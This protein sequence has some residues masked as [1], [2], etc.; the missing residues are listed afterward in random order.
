M[1]KGIPRKALLPIKAILPVLAEIEDFPIQ[2]SLDVESLVLTRI[3]FEI[4]KA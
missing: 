3:I 2:F 1:Q 4:P